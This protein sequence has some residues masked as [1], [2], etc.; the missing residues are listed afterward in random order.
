MRSL[1]I[2]NLEAGNLG[3]AHASP[4]GHPLVL[5]A[6]RGLEQSRRLVE[7]QHDRQFTRVGYL[8]QLAREVRSVG[9]V[10]EEEAQRRYDAVHRRHWKA[11][12]ALL[13]LKAAQV[14]GCGRVWPTSQEHRE[15]PDVANVVVLRRARK[16]AH[17]YVV[18]QA[19]A[20]RADRRG[21]IENVHLR[22]LETRT[23][24]APPPAQAAQTGAQIAALT[25]ISQHA[26]SR[27]AGSFS[28]QDAGA[29]VTADEPHR[30]QTQSNLFAVQ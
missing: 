20:Q 9:R 19:L 14:L 4:I 21:E 5:E 12:L 25:P 2:A 28:G 7:A 26:F 17:G 10:R 6:G 8:D 30:L 29:I 3:N 16:L 22:F 24:D 23:F 1:E 18:D 27:E 13:D 11:G 15:A